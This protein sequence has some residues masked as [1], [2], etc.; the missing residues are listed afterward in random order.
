MNKHTLIMKY[1]V[2]RTV[3]V[4]EQQKMNKLKSGDENVTHIQG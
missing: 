2:K 4:L 3:E 1:G